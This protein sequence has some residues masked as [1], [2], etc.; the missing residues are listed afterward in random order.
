MHNDLEL[1]NG[2]LPAYVSRVVPLSS[3]LACDVFERW[4]S[5]T[6]RRS[7]GNDLD[8]I[9]TASGRIVLDRRTL[10][11]CDGASAMYPYRRVCGKLRVGARRAWRVELELAP[12]S[13]SHSEL[14]FRYAGRRVPM[15]GAIARYH[16]VG[17]ALLAHL[18]RG[19]AELR[20]IVEAEARR[21]AA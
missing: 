18:E 16:A 6:S 13:S 7:R 20:P 2:S 12:W 3:R 19:F 4:W 1:M 9:E 11:R 14:G 5:E 8:A 21:H 15:P 10:Q 17:E